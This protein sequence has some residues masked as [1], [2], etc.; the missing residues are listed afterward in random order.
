LFKILL[1]S[2]YNFLVFKI[3]NYTCYV[4]VKPRGVRFP[5]KLFSS[6]ISEI[7]TRTYIFFFTI[8]FS[9]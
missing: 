9:K 1:N 6:Y 8:L 7:S 5:A 2:W 4:K 3:Q